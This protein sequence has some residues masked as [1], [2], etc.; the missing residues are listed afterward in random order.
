MAAAADA[1]AASAA[2]SGRPLEAGSCAP[3]EE[4]A[5]A[6]AAVPL[7]MRRLVRRSAASES[8]AL[9]SQGGQ[10]RGSGYRV[11]GC[12]RRRVAKMGALPASRPAESTCALMND[13]QI[14]PSGLCLAYER[15][16]QHSSHVEGLENCLFKRLKNSNVD[17]DAFEVELRL[18][19]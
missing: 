17:R 15:H 12:A 6:A 19:I 8:S 1:D 5:T 10:C 14:N 16:A 7:W 9:C 2:A 3:L 18:R 11:L 13:V 4:G